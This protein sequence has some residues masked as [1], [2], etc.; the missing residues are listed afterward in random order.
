MIDL[1]VYSYAAISTAGILAGLYW[2]FT[3]NKG[4]K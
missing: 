4:E 3:E 1:F 2:T